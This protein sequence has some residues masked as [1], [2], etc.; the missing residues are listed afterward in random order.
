MSAFQM[1]PFIV[2][3]DLNRTEVSDCRVKTVLLYWLSGG[4]RDQSHREHK[5]PNLFGNIFDGHFVN[6]KLS[7]STC[8]GTIQK[9]RP[10]N[11]SCPCA[12]SS[13][14]YK[15]NEE[16]PTPDEFAIFL[17]NIFASEIG[18]ESPDLNS[19]VREMETTGFGDVEPFTMADLQNALK[20]LRRNK[21]ADSCGIVD[22]SLELHEHLLRL[23]N[24]MLVDGHVERDGNTQ[25]FQ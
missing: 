5:Y 19:L 12:N 23:F 7:D 8:F 24:L 20:N 4:W 9:F 21:C 17:E 1:S 14:L 13:L 16:Y 15:K 11:S 10:L 25:L 22:G 3:A 6:K 2:T 18:F